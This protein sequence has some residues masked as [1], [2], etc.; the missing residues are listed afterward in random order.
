MMEYFAQI[1]KSFRHLT[2]FAKFSNTNALESH[3]Y[4]S[5]AHFVIT[6]ILRKRCWSENFNILLLFNCFCFC[7]CSLFCYHC[8]LF[9]IFSLYIIK[10]Y[11][12]EVHSIF[13]TTCLIFSGLFQTLS[14]I[15]DKF[16]LWKAVKY[17]HKK[18]HHIM[19]L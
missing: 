2:N 11:I 10:V 9:Y 15:C 4:T 6:F 12:D 13:Y 14:N 16:F 1:I 5:V 18:L 17:F 8:V 7:C 19:K 3:K